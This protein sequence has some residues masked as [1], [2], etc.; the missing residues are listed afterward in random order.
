MPTTIK[1]ISPEGVVIKTPSLHN[2]SSYDHTF[3]FDENYDPYIDT[4]SFILSEQVCAEYFLQCIID[5]KIT[6]SRSPVFIETLLELSSTLKKTSTLTHL[7]KKTISY[8]INNFDAVMNIEEDEYNED[9]MLENGQLYYGIGLYPFYH[10]VMTATRRAAWIAVVREILQVIDLGIEW[11]TDINGYTCLE[12]YDGVHEEDCTLADIFDNDTIYYGFGSESVV[13][14]HIIER[15]YLSQTRWIVEFPNMPL[16]DIYHFR[17]VAYTEA[18]RILKFYFSCKTD[19]TTLVYDEKRT[20]ISNIFSGGHN[21]TCHSFKLYNN[22][23]AILYI[24]D[25]MSSNEVKT[26]KIL[27]SRQFNQLM[28]IITKIVFD[29]HEP[30]QSILENQSIELLTSNQICGGTSAMIALCKNN[31]ELRIGDNSLRSFSELHESAGSLARMIS[32]IFD[33]KFY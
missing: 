28:K 31:L 1:H 8:L 15:K 9:S 17:K 16:C 5:G 11:E 10:H 32:K 33:I 4:K 2:Y 25:E 13:N 12:L 22:H 6:I 29:I 21:S 19:F 24:Q 18:E 7:Y 3:I 30:R 26:I 20:L 23:E 14:S 27:S